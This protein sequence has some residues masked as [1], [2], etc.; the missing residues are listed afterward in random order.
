MRICQI[1]T[2]VCGYIVGN[3]HAD[4]KRQAL[5]GGSQENKHTNLGAQRFIQLYI[6]FSSHSAWQH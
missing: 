5:Q 2:D 6:E 3:V 1:T 4:A